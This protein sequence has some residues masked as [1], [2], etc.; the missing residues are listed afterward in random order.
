MGTNGI[1]MGFQRFKEMAFKQQTWG[2]K[3]FKLCWVCH[4]LLGFINSGFVQR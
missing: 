4:G 2:F 1:Q 3:G